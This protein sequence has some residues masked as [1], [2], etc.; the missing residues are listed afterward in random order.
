MTEYSA[1]CPRPSCDDKRV[2]TT[3]YQFDGRW[4]A[5]TH[6]GAIGPFPTRQRAIDARNAVLTMDWIAEGRKSTYHIHR[7]DRLLPSE[8]IDRIYGTAYDAAHACE[9]YAGQLGVDVLAT[10]EDTLIVEYRAQVAS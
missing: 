9:L 3:T 7:A 6:Q 4:Y 5:R 10:D 2:E 8:R 1:T